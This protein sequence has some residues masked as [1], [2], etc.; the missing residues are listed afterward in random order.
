MPFLRE[1]ETIEQLIKYMHTLKVQHGLIA[2]EDSDVAKQINSEMHNE[3]AQDLIKQNIK[4]GKM[5]EA[6]TREKD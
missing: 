4:D 2:P 3:Q 6:Y 1:I 5:E